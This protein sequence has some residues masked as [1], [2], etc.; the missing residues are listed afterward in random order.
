M[1]KQTILIIEDDPT[2]QELFAEI[3]SDAGFNPVVTTTTAEAVAALEARSFVLA[4]VDI[5]LSLPDHADRGGIDVLRAI[6]KLPVRLP[7]IVVTGYATVDLAVET[8]AELNAR[9]FF[10][11]EEFNRRKF[12]ETLKKETTVDN[13]VAVLSEREREVLNLMGEGLTNKQIA[14]KL[15]VSVNTVKKHIQNIFTKL[16]VESRAAAVAKAL[17]RRG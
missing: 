6:A 11:K 8:L 7:S 16:N 10:R 5:S 14:E 2:W 13:P 12:I 17:K 3:V 15:I 4:I 9:H 1:T